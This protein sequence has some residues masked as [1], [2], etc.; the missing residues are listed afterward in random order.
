MAPYVVDASIATK[1]FLAEEFAAIAGRLRTMRVALH[2][3]A[4]FYLE[5]GHVVCKKYRRN[6]IVL[7]ECLQMIRDMQRVP[8]QRHADDALFAIALH[9]A[10]ELRTGIYDCLYLSLAT[11]LNC[12]FITADKRFVRSVADTEYADYVLWIED[13]PVA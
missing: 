5:F 2:V 11:Q 10:L 12:P 7:D 9:Q 6:E 1:W 13:L 3:P 8:L 4:F